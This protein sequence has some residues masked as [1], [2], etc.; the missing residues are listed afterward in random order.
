MHDGVNFIITDKFTA[1]DI[2]VK[3]RP[4]YIGKIDVIKPS[5]ISH[6]FHIAFSKKSENYKKI[7]SDFNQG[8]KMISDDGTLTKILNTHGIFTSKASKNGKT[9]LPLEQLKIIKC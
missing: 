4:N 5:I 3:Q 2:I 7:Q 8:L 1:A 6:P 9:K